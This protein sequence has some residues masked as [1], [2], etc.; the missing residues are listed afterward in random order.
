MQVFEALGFA[1]RGLGL[2]GQALAVDVDRAAGQVMDGLA[3][4]AEREAEVAVAELVE[5]AAALGGLGGDAVEHFDARHARVEPEQVAGVAVDAVDHLV[6]RA[7][8]G[9]PPV[10]AHVARVGRVVE[11]EVIL[12]H[13]FALDGRDGVGGGVIAE[14]GAFGAGEV[15][16]AVVL[17][18]G[19][20]AADGAVSRGRRRLR[21]GRT[22]CQSS[23]WFLVARS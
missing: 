17:V 11:A 4:R 19:D 16:R 5:H 13:V 7:P 9:L 20:G 22:S 3:V 21:R 6:A 23:F 12:L 15:S 2:A 8:E 14:D 18:H 1:H 10:V